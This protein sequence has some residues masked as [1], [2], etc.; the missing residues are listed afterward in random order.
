MAEWVLRKINLGVF[1]MPETGH[2]INKSLPCS[3]AQLL[4]FSGILILK[5][6]ASTWV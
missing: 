6:L 2:V 5:H 3:P 4:S 1:R